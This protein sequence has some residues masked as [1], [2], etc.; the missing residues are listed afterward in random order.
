MA[1]IKIKRATGVITLPNFV[2]LVQY[3]DGKIRKYDVKPLIKEIKA[4]RQL[5]R[6]KTLFKKVRIGWNGKALV[7][8]DKL[9]FDATE[10][11]YDGEAV[12]GLQ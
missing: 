9:D 2:L 8:N 10:I 5:K 4:F 11:Y 1:T 3:Q 12:N 7:W 6:D